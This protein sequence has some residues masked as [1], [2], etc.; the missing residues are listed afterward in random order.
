MSELVFETG[1]I[2]GRGHALTLSLFA[3]AALGVVCLIAP[4]S[5]H[6]ILVLLAPVAVGVLCWSAVYTMHH[7]SWLVLPLL[8]IELL[9]SASFIGDTVRGVAR[10]SL[11]SLFCLPLLPVLWHCARKASGS[12]PSISA[13]RW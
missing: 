5:G 11:E 10:Y 8:L 1:Q 13:W 4:P 3:A 2:R 9:T 6:F 7:R 12:S